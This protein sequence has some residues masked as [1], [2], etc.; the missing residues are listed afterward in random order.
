ML[1]LLAGIFVVGGGVFYL[2]TMSPG[3][4]VVLYGDT[5]EVEAES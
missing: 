5:E 3:E 4:E 1:F 2:Q